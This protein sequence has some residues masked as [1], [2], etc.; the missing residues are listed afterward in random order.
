ML[1][2]ISK[3]KAL[4]ATDRISWR[5][6]EHAREQKV[7]VREGGGRDSAARADRMIMLEKA[8][9]EL[10]MRGIDEMAEGESKMLVRGTGDMRAER[11]E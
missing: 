5:E 8:R 6:F 2:L 10:Q 1:L 9:A 3:F 11:G 4:T 7:R